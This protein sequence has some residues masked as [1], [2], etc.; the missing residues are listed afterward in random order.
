MT[1]S[2]LTVALC[3][4][5]IV[6]CAG[7][8]RLQ[9]SSVDN[10]SALD[11]YLQLYPGPARNVDTVAVLAGY[12]GFG[13]ERKIVEVRQIERVDT[14]DIWSLQGGHAIEIMPGRY[15]VHLRRLDARWTAEFAAKP[16]IVYSLV[17]DGWIEGYTELEYPRLV[18]VASPAVSV[19]DVRSRQS[20]NRA[21]YLQPDAPP[22]GSRYVQVLT[23]VS[24]QST[25]RVMSIARWER[26]DAGKHSRGAVERY[27]GAPSRISKD[28]SGN[29]VSEYD[30][31]VFVTEREE[32][33]RNYSEVGRTL[34]IR[35]DADGKIAE[36]IEP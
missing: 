22:E 28:D 19:T 20:E 10:D 15:K 18:P 5:L 31:I 13:V 6:G 33:K 16:G 12:S 32:S 11:R 2:R 14:G 23:G 26:L 29:E 30:G 25:N 17:Q 7:T 4:C 21:L 35:F 27:L 36:I 34:H 3:A 1:S 24:M 8:P 9:Q